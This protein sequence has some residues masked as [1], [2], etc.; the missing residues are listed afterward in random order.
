MIPS[1]GTHQVWKY[2]PRSN[3]LSHWEPFSQWIDLDFPEFLERVVENCPGYLTEYYPGSSDRLTGRS[4]SSVA[5]K[6]WSMISCWHSG[7]LVRT[8]TKK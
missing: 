7:W 2:H 1:R 3:P 6:G 5:T 4:T 8:L